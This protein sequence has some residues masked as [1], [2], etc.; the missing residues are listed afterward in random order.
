MYKVVRIVADGL[1][2]QPDIRFSSSRSQVTAVR[3][4]NNRT[5]YTAHDKSAS[6][7]VC[8]LHYR[9]SRDD[10]RRSFPRKTKG[11]GIT[12]LAYFK[13][14]DT[15]AVSTR[16]CTVV[17]LQYKRC[18]II[19][20]LVGWWLVICSRASRSHHGSGDFTRKGATYRYG[21]A[22]DVA[23]TIIV[24]NAYIYAHRSA[25]SKIKTNVKCYAMLHHTECRL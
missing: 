7:V 13:T 1:P 20:L 23:A 16:R 19:D 18:I 25:R 9:R 8:S 24:Y 10:F 2:L 22:H 3:Y 11:R 12:G 17:R 21:G 4:Y 5:E 14:F 6:S 15:S